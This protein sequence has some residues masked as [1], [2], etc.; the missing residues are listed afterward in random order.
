MRF[1]SS[2]VFGIFFGWWIEYEYEYEGCV[3]RI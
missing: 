1:N 3:I 2:Y